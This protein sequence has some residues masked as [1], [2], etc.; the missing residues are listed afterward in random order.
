MAGFE[1]SVKR[2]MSDW[3]AL[4]FLGWW[5]WWCWCCVFSR[6]A[7]GYTR[8]EQKRRGWIRACHVVGNGHGQQL[9]V[10]Q[11]SFPRRSPF[12]LDSSTPFHTGVYMILILY[13]THA[14]VNF[15]LGPLD[16]RP[17]SRHYLY[18]YVYNRS[19]YLY[20]L[21]ACVWRR[22]D[23]SNV[24]F[25]EQPMDA[26]KSDSRDVFRH[27]SRLSS[28]STHITQKKKKILIEKRRWREGGGRERERENVTLA[29]T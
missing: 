3:C 27:V 9:F 23:Q 14:G 11:H 25:Y 29:V 5:W 4:L 13:W 16:P 24:V 18:L 19:R 10:Q 22:I 28:T 21:F 17:S 15:P 12:S 7:S 8:L 20:C 6:M 2:P 1:S 26:T